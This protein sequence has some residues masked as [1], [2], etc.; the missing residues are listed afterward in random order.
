MKNYFTKEYWNVSSGRS[1]IKFIEN[2]EFPFISMSART[3]R[4][5]HWQ[6][7]LSRWNSK[8]EPISKVF[9]FKKLS[10]DKYEEIFYWFLKSDEGKHIIFNYLFEGKW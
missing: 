8:T 9:Y 10:K 2:I 7:S 1:Y 5:K 3:T 6:I 4:Q